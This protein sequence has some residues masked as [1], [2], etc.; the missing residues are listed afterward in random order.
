MARQISDQLALAQNYEKVL[1]RT[2]EQS[3]GLNDALQQLYITGDELTSRADEIAA[4]MRIKADELGQLQ[5]VADTCRA[6]SD[7]FGINDATTRYFEKYGA[8]EF[9]GGLEKMVCADREAV[10]GKIAEVNNNHSAIKHEINQ[11]KHMRAEIKQQLLE[12]LSNMYEQ[13]A[14][15][16]RFAVRRGLNKRRVCEYLCQFAD[17][18]DVKAYRHGLA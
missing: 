14:Q 5:I 3:Y 2:I 12:H 8:Y 9:L 11:N 6:T 16:Y 17:P 13:I 4:K 18:H 7:M 1:T 15:Y 10:R